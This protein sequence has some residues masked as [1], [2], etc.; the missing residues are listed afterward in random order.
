VAT[1]RPASSAAAQLGLP[2]RRPTSTSTPESCRFSAWAW[3]WLPYPT[4]ATLPSRRVRSPSR[5]IVAI[6]VGL[7]S[8]ECALEL[9]PAGGGAPQADAAELAD[10]VPPEQLL[11]RVDLLRL[12]DD[13]EHDRLRADVGDPGVEHLRQREQL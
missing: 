7:L 9:G 5:R 11:E 3:P 8:G 13:L 1:E 2:S 6:G 10:A 4:T 12:A